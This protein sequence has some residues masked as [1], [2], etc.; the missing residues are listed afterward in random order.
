VQ[1]N[2]GFVLLEQRREARA[3]IIDR[4]RLADAHSVR[5]RVA[6]V[7]VRERGDAGARLRARE[8]RRERQLVDEADEV[9]ERKR[10]A[11]ERQ[12]IEFD[13]RLLVGADRHRLAHDDRRAAVPRVEK[14]PDGLGHHLK[15]DAF[16]QTVAQRRPLVGGRNDETRVVDLARRFVVVVDVVVGGATV[17]RIAATVVGLARILAV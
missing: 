8:A 2:R 3:Q 10:H 14:E 16:T 15:V 6:G 1:A 4:A 5:L 17:P 11:D 13:N 9:L 12:W 7:K